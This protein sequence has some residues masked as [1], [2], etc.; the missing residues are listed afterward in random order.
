MI[1]DIIQTDLKQSQID[2]DELRT[3]VL[4][5]LLSEIRYAEIRQREGE[6]SEL[7]DEE[8]VTVIQKEIKK[9]KE[10]ADGFK[11]GGRE[12]SAKKEE[13]EAAVLVKYLPAQLTDEQL[14]ELIDQ[15]AIEMNASGI[16]DMGKVI[17]AVLGKVKGQADGSR[18]SILVKE[19]LVG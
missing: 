8:I 15:V 9:R 19:K 10:A 17:G 13:A 3:N 4:R 7:S 5:M 11:Q 14:K 6:R 2:K 12:E 18:V 1:L 16:Q